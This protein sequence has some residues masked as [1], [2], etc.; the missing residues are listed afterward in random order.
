MASRTSPPN[1]T[2]ASDKTVIEPGCGVIA[3][4]RAE[5]ESRSRGQDQRRPRSLP[6]AE[7]TDLNDPADRRAALEGLDIA[8]ADVM[9][10]TVRAGRRIMLVP[11][12]AA[13]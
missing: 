9:G 3:P 13:S 10:A 6:I 11:E 8:N 12:T 4:L 2:L 5:V 7:A 1:P